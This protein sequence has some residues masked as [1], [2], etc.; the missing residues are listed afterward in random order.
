MIRPGKVNFY[1]NNRDSL[2]GAHNDA[3][4]TNRLVACRSQ[5]RIH[6]TN[7]I[8]WAEL[9]FF[10]PFA[11]ISVSKCIY[12]EKLERD[13]HKT[14]R[15]EARSSSLTIWIIKQQWERE[16]VKDVMKQLERFV[17]LK[18]K[19]PSVTHHLGRCLISSRF[20]VVVVFHVFF[21]K[22][23]MLREFTS[24][25]G[26]RGCDSLVY[27]PTFWKSVGKMKI[28]SFHYHSCVSRIAIL[29]MREREMEL[30]K[31]ENLIFILMRFPIL[32]L[33]A[34]RRLYYVWQELLRKLRA[35][36]N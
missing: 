28:F 15:Y 7:W 22:I 21:L 12:A 23:Y 26:C 10:L 33:T 17:L 36:K 2:D 5:R 3:H 30:T 4:L 20:I 18:W 11:F 8:S 32:A 19:H 31:T 13:K 27:R 24:N 29:N 34:R 16:R 35:R 1:C 14:Y 25:A 9:E 6:L